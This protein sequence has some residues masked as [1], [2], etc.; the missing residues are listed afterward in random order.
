ME[1]EWEDEINKQGREKKT[2]EEKTRNS[3]R[4]KGKEKWHTVGKVLPE[5]EIIENFRLGRIDDEY[6][7]KWN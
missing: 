2:N 3:K 5:K 6:N 1:Y 4:Y 7:E